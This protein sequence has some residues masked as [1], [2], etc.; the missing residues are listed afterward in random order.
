MLK[1]IAITGIGMVTPLGQEP[2]AVL[3][4]MEAGE[5]AGRAHDF[6]V[7][8]GKVAWVENF[9][10]QD[11]LAREP[12]M[13]RL[14]NREAQLAVAAAHLALV[15]A[16]IQVNEIFGN[17]RKTSENSGKFAADEVGVY[18]ATGLAGLPLREVLPLLKASVGEDGLLDLARFGNSGLRSISPLLSFKILSNMPVCFVSICENIQGPNGIYTPWEGQGAQAIE[19]GMRAVESGQAKCALVGGCDVKTHE[20]V[21]ISLQQLGLFQSWE[22]CGAGMVP[23]EGAVFLV[24]EDEGAAR[25]RGARVYARV[26]DFN[27]ARRRKKVLRGET[28][29]AVL[30]KF[31]LA[32]VGALVS[33]ADGDGR[34]A[35]DEARAL[36]SFNFK[37]GQ[38]VCPKQGA[39]NLFAA[40]AALQ[41]AVGALVAG[42]S[43]KRVLANCFGYGSEQ[44]AF[45]LEPGGGM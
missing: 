30:G 20:L 44:G 18:G 3:G 34:R 39:G 38:V 37:A 12:K 1:K 5:M 16:G 32:S 29:R 41:V 15:D 28:Y 6:P 35:G 23:G 25:A 42:Q 31:D 9:Q 11:Y 36:E 21:L 13:L 10:P 26:A 4:R 17:F 19:A 45:V 43:G 33:A 27:F 2:A 14:M 22:D 24:L 8:C 7:A 40:A